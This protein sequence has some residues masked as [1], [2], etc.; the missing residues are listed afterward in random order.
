MVD[1]Q[2]SFF[3]SVHGW[4]LLH[5]KTKAQEV[6]TWMEVKMGWTV[7]VQAEIR[8]RMDADN[9]FPQAGCKLNSVRSSVDERRAG[10]VGW[11]RANL[12]VRLRTKALYNTLPGKY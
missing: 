10:R 6:G 9:I 11:E 7:K 3:M 2:H 4:K 8:T 1:N 5:E 12:I